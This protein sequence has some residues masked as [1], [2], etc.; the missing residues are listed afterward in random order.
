MKKEKTWKAVIAILTCTTIVFA[1]LFG[2]QLMKSGSAAATGNFTNE[3]KIP[4]AVN[5][6]D[7][8]ASTVERNGDHA[9]SPYFYDVDFYN[10]KSTDSFTI[11]PQFP[12]I[13]QTS[14]W[15]CG[16]S[17]SMMVMDYYDKLDDWNEETLADLRTDHS[18][19]HDGTCLDQM[20]EIFDKVGGF[21][22]ETTYDYADNLDAIDMKWFREHLEAGVPILIGWNDWGAHWQV[23]IGYDTMGTQYEGDD[24][25]IVA[26]SFDTTDHNQDGYG[27]LG[28][29][30]FI[31]NFTFFDFFPENEPRDK[32]FIAVKPAA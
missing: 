15:S 11:L 17:A 14:W 9:D 29:E 19:L 20:I 31:Y 32:C 24:V 12:T 8:G 18:S 26:D 4:Y 30:R 21:E 2:W 13:Q 27:V 25:L 5:L 22:L 28:M 10:A 6:N 7:A 1:G 16:I 23:A 3:M